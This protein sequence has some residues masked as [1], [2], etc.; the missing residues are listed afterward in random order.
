MPKFH[1][2]KEVSAKS[3]GGMEIV[4]EQVYEK[5]LNEASNDQLWLPLPKIAITN[6]V[7]DL[8]HDYTFTHPGTGEV[9]KVV[10]ERQ[11]M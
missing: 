2:L 11:Y 3:S 8:S 5:V 9:F 4:V 10:G 1:T 6:K 7:I